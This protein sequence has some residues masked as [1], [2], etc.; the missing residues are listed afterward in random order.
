MKL[1]FGQNEGGLETENGKTGKREDVPDTG[2]R[3]GLV[4]ETGRWDE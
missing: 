3:H 2:V 1:D 4:L